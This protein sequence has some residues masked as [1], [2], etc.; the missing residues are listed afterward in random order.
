MSTRESMKEQS[1]QH[2][3]ESKSEFDLAYLLERIGQSDMQTTAYDTAWVARLSEFDPDLGLPALEWLCCNQLPDGSWGSA[4]PY[5]YP[6]RLISTLS[7]MIALSYRGRR[8]SDKR[9]IEKGLEALEDITDN[10]TKG[11]ANVLKGPTVGFEMIVPTLVEQAEELGIIR[12]QKE[13]ILGKIS[14]QRA[15]KLSLIKGEM[16]NRHVTMAFSAEM[17]GVDGQHMLDSDNLQERNGSVGCSPS[18]TAYFALQVKREEKKAIDYLY[19]SRSKSGGV[20]NVAPFD[21]FEVAWTLWNLSLMPEYP[22]AYDQVQHHIDFLSRVWDRTN[23]AGF[24]SE[25]SVND[26]DETAVVYETLSRHGIQKNVDSIFEFEEEDHFRCFDL[27]NFPSISANIHVLGA[28]RQAGFDQSHPSVKKILAFLQKNRKNENYWDDKWHFSPFY[29][30][31]HAIMVCAGYANDIVSGAVDWL[32]KMQKPDGSWGI[33]GSTPEETSYALQALWVW[34]QT[35]GQIPKELFLNGK[36]WLSDHRSEH[37]PLWIGK[38]LY[39]PV[40][41][42]DSAIHCAISLEI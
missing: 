22:V 15:E 42:V 9:Q 20:P 34:N 11:L 32:L 10:A 38:C 19:Q 25:Y 13:R 18:A 30:T 31:S 1:K 8:Q 4:Q 26:S 37:P 6:D 33:T 35:A 3:S 2:D 17:A 14:K 5:Y 29:T 16:I 28:L 23:G 36:K 12:Q 7:A 24:S 41:V 40:L 39:S 27:E 21:V